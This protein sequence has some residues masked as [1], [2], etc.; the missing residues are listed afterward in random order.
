MTLTGFFA[1]NPHFQNWLM[2]AFLYSKSLSDINIP[3]YC[4]TWQSADSS[5]IFGY[6]PTIR[7]LADDIIGISKIPF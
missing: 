3:V 6:K 7:K 4:A 5:T 1:I 2:A